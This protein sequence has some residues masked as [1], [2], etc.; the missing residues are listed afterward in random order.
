MLWRDGAIAPGTVAPLDHT[1]RGLT[2]GDG[3]FD[4]ALALG[5]RVAFEDAHVARLVASA[6]SLGMPAE[7][8]RI[9]AAMR[10][11]AGQGER[12][13]IRTTL[14]RGSGSRPSST[15]C[16]RSRAAPRGPAGS[17]ARAGR[18]ARP[19]KVPPQGEDIVRIQPAG[20]AFPGGRRRHG[21][22]HQRRQT[23]WPSRRRCRTPSTRLSRTST[24]P[25]SSR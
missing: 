8:E 2:L 12:L 4:T 14:T 13:A 10:G 7:A 22:R 6:E 25:R 24:M 11:L 23:E 16:A 1:D 19:R 3:L 18:A 9:R 5:G 20:P 21:E 17:R 15:A